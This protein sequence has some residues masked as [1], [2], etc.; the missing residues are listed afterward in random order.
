MKHKLI[1]IAPLMLATL[2]FSGSLFAQNW[3]FV[4]EKDGV[5]L[6]TRQSAGK[7]LKYFKGIAEI[8]T[9]AERIYSK[10]ED[11]YQTDWWTKDVTQIK[12]LSYAKDRLAQYYLVYDLP[13]PF[14]D[15]DLCVNV[16]AFINHT[17]GERRLTAVPMQGTCVVN[18]QC[19]RM[20]E[21]WE[22][23]RIRP[24]DK[25]RSLVE[26]EFYINPGTHLPDWIVNMVLTDSPIKV[27]RAMRRTL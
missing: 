8:N 27:I 2:L 14:K 11:V 6:Y 18:N 10:L 23:W 3:K 12:V 13:W 22:E 9:P 5:Q 4:K 21:F 17:T 25:N 16:T 7:G 26:L 15:R 24:I 1:Y 20:K 19:V